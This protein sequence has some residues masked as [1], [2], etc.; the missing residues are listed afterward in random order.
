MFPDGEVREVAASG[1][2]SVVDLTPILCHGRA[3]A[4]RLGLK[5]FPCFDALELFAFV[6]PG[7]ICLPTIK[8]LVSAVGLPQP[9]SLNQEALSLVE[10]VRILLRDVLQWTHSDSTNAI[11][12]AQVLNGAGWPWGSSVLS[13]A[14]LQ[15]RSGGVGLSA[16]RVWSRLEPFEDHA[17]PPPP[18]NA[19]VTED[20]SAAKLKDILGDQSENR[21]AQVQYS[22]DI[23]HAFRAKQAPDEPNV[24]LAEAGTGV[25]KTL[26]YLAPATLWAEKNAGPVWVSTYTRNLQRQLEQELDQVFPQPE[27]KDERVAIRKGRENYFCLLNYEEALNRSGTD[28][29]SIIPLGLIARWITTTRSGDMAGG[30][31]PSWLSDLFGLSRVMSL[32]DRRGECIYASCPHYRSCFVE[33]TVRRARTADIVVANHALVMVQASLGGLDDATQPTRY[34]FDEGHHLFGAADSAFSTRLSAVE[35]ADLR[36]WLIGA[37]A[38]ARFSRARGLKRR[39]GDLLDTLDQDLETLAT[40]LDAVLQA[41]R[42]LSAP[43]WRSRLEDQQPRGPAEHFLNR[44]RTQVYAR[45]ESSS[46]YSLQTETIEPI[47]GL[48]DA[49]QDLHSA[50]SRLLKPLKRLIQVLS[51]QLDRPAD[52]IDVSIR[53]R[54]DGLCR[55]LEL[56]ASVPLTAWCDMLD[57]LTTGT[58][59]EFVDWFGIDRVDGRDVDV[60]FFRHW[61]DPTLPFARTVLDSAHGVAITS[62]TL[63]D[64]TGDE[65]H[66][67]AYAE[68]QVGAH[69]IAVTLARSDLPSPFDYEAAMRIFIVTDVSR[70]SLVQVAH[71]YRDLFL[72]SNGGALGLFTAIARLKATYDQIAPALEAEGIPLYAQHVDPLPT[73]TLV[74]I[75]REEEKTCLLGTDAIRDGVDVPGNAL[76]LMVFDRVPWPRPDILHKARREAF[77]RKGYDDRITRMRL[78]QAFGRLI[79]RKGDKGVFVMLDSRTPSRLLGAFPEETPVE[80]LELAEVVAMTAAFLDEHNSSI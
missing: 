58:P 44:V 17:P 42:S 24:V 11:G 38:G 27:D 37:E 34:I 73:S 13:A 68:Q 80:R 64:I 75:F 72:A 21:N 32:A 9:R 60:G 6:R 30:D 5:P 66:D 54:I 31:F 3:T 15:D 76:R 18:G 39:M 48:L 59:E 8:G 55:S 57:S 41:A 7:Q 36:Q 45:S 26:G 35:T 56:R 40:S 10:I 28:P 49:A 29:S 20:E 61:I 65:R 51:V 2:K 14:S 74:D 47:D 22:R 33:K 62:A 50:L 23:S 79:R 53:S 16:L 43:G 63:R 52:D 19:P 46:P 1:A 77:G 69:H 12:I 70:D 25:G 4:A 67:W 78:K 71:A